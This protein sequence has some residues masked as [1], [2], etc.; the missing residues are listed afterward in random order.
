MPHIQQHVAARKRG[1]GLFLEEL[2]RYFGGEGDYD[3]CVE[4]SGIVWVQFSST[5]AVCLA[6]LL[7]FR[8][9]SPEDMLI[10]AYYV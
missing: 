10:R 6:I 7:Y 3:T 5:G 9:P 4:A 1:E 2:S 8:V